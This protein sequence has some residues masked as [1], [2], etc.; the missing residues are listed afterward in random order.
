MKYQHSPK[1]SLSS[2]PDTFFGKPGNITFALRKGHFIWSADN[3]LFV[4]GKE[5]MKLPEGYTSDKMFH[6]NLMHLYGLITGK[7]EYENAKKEDLHKLIR[8]RT[9]P[10]RTTFNIW[11]TPSPETIKEIL[12]L[13]IRYGIVKKQDKYKISAT[14]RNGSYTY[15][16]TSQ[17]LSSTIASPHAAI[18]QKLYH[19]L[20]L[21]SKKINKL[22]NN[23]LEQLKRLY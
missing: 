2:S 10:D 8:G 18:R 21:E 11:G 22:L 20:G 9:S 16:F 23:L 12:K 7:D 4:D 15:T 14:G 1:P 17:D 6:K 19:K 13:A 5:V 3:K